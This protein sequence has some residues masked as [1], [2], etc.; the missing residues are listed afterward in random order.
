MAATHQK[1][2]AE[3]QL[4]NCQHQVLDDQHQPVGTQHQVLD[5]QHQPVGTQHQVLNGQ[6]QPVG[7]QH[8]V[9]DG[10]HQPVG[11]QHQVLNGQHQPNVGHLTFDVRLLRVN[12]GALSS[13]FHFPLSTVN[14]LRP[15]FIRVLWKLS[16]KI[17]RNRRRW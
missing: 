4:P 3:P 6:H 2:E 5:G 11:A 17:D 16:S 15:V 8:Q 9:L 12:V 14:C 10:Q 13:T 1:L 7:T